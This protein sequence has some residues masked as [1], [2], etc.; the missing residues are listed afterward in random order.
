MKMYFS[1]CCLHYY[2]HNLYSVQAKELTGGFFKDN[3]NFLFR[4]V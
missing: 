2:H 3:V 1:I 4:N